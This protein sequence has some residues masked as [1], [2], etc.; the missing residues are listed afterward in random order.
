[1]AR[2]TLV[3]FVVAGIALTFAPL[4]AHAAEPITK[5]SK[6]SLDDNG[7]LVIDG[8]KVFPITLTIVPGPDAKAP[9]GKHAYEE[10]ADSGA[11]FMRSGKPDWNGR[12]SP[13]R[14]P[15]RPRP[16]LTAC[17]AAPGSAGIWQTSTP[18]TPKGGGA[19]AGHRDV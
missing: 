8:R 19:A 13:S 1:M 16:P 14:K 4:A 12:R 11:L 7:V 17:A 10:F 6:I 15:P 18:A 9:S 5:P 3:R 2:K